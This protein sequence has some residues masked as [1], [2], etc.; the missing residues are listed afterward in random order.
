[1]LRLETPAPL[2]KRET[3]SRLFSVVIPAYNT[4]T[5]I[6]D[7]L[8]SVFAQRLE[9]YEV[10]VVNDGS[11]DSI[12]LERELKPYLGRIRYIKQ[13]HGGPGSARN[14]GIRIAKGEYIAFLD[15]DDMWLPS[16]LADMARLL[17]HDPTL[18]LAYADAAFFGDTESGGRT[19]MEMNP[20]EGLATFESL[21]DEKCSV[22]SSTVVARRL[23]II[24]AGLFDENFRF[25]EDFD[26]W[27]RIANQGGHLGYSRAIHAQRRIHENNLTADIVSS[28]SGQA[29]VLEKLLREL[30][31][32]SK[33]KGKMRLE[34]QRCCASMALEKGKQ[35]LIARQYARAWEELRRANGFFRSHKLYIAL[36][37]LRSAPELLRR[38]YMKR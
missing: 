29:A 5:F 13:E 33:V 17:A 30:T 28:F 23:A 12:E 16:H 35:R 9:A 26:L 27:L 8:N 37:L 1:M 21:V 20:S 6:A 18:D 22:I 11:P 24:D 3:V 34:I 32:P 25:G 10:I 19:C 36:F 14:R 31:L 7:A 38:L 15:S 4:A 2:H